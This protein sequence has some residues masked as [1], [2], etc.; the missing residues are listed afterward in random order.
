MADDN[1]REDDS[2]REEDHEGGPIA[3]E[4]AAAIVEKFPGSIAA[5][6]HGQAVVY[7]DRAVLAD[8]ARF[9]RDE[10]EFTMCVDVSAV[11]HLLTGTRHRPPGVDPERFE[12]VVNF[13][14]HPRNRRV[15]VICQV[16]A[17]DP[18]VPS[19]TGVYVGTNFAERETFDLYGIAFD[20]HPDLTRILMPDDWHGFPLR[21]DDAP[22][23]VPVTFKGDPSPR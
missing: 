14:S 9:L 7:V 6:S 18:T 23:R 5:D 4:V 15:R 16:P 8:V 12:I 22:G 2:A 20:G 3:D 19:L 21:K 1:A 10:Q 11:D 17:S 13:L